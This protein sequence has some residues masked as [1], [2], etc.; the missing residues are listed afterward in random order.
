MSTDVS[1]IPEA[2]ETIRYRHADDVWSAA[3]DLLDQTLLPETLSRLICETPGQLHDAIRRLVVRGAPA[4]GIA[5]AY[6]VTLTRVDSRADAA[7]VR[8]RYLETIDYLATSR[9]TAVNLFW[10]LDRMKAVV[11]SVE[12]AELE[13]LPN[14]LAD[15]AIRIHEDDRAMCRSI[16]INGAPLLQGCQNVLTHCNAGGLATSTLGTALAPIYHLHENGTTLH[17]YA[18]ETRPLLQGAR[19][20]AWELSQAG[21]PVTVCTDSMAGGLMKAGNVDAVIVGADRIAANGDA[22]NKIGT[23]PLAILAHY[24]HIPFYVAAPTNTFDMALASGDLIP[25]EQRDPAEVTQPGGPSG[26][27]TVPASAKVT[28]P[29]FDVTPAELITAIITERGVIQTPNQANVAEVLNA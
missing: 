2:A 8:S 21:I 6:G 12:D 24:H 15:E 27:T 28:N 14:R 10:A 29:A 16:G 19:L 9:P 7:A 22:A 20:T 23:Y 25:I 18:D 11:Q 26:R 13:M 3:V 4:I 5:A 17:V 1:G